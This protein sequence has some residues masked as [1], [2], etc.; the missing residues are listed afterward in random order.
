MT[1]IKIKTHYVASIEKVFDINRNI[2][3]HQFSAIKTKEKA[4][5]GVI[6]GLINKGETVTWRGKHFGFYIQHQSIIS[7]MTIPTYFVDEQV[8][9]HFKSFKHQHFFEQK[10]NYVEVTDI[11]EYQTPFGIIG[12]LFDY[13]F[14]KKHLIEFIKHRNNVLK[15]CLEKKTQ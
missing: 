10:E 15:N 14:L 6:T 1:T 2:D 11:I 4:I 7:E 8:N 3:F 9:G 13:F 5:A 12:K